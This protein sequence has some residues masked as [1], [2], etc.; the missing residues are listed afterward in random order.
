[1]I[2][3]INAI[4]T[5][6]SPKNPTTVP[7]LVLGKFERYPEGGYKNPFVIPTRQGSQIVVADMRNP[8]FPLD[9]KD[10]HLEGGGESDGGIFLVVRNFVIFEQARRWFLISQ[11]KF[12][13][14]KYDQPPGDL[15]VGACHRALSSDQDLLTHDFKKAALV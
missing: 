10:Y 1:M 5:F 14:G 15:L 13:C 8:V 4:S 6:G 2:M 11:D 9:L 12:T 3:N 7:G